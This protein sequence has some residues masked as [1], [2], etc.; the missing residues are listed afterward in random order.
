MSQ[1]VPT[2]EQ[3]LARALKAR[4]KR[5]ARAA[6]ARSHTRAHREAVRARHFVTLLA[7]ALKLP[8]DDARYLAT[9]GAASATTTEVAGFTFRLDPG[10]WRAAVLLVERCCPVCG[11]QFVQR[12]ARKPADFGAIAQAYLHHADQHTPAA[13]ADAGTPVESAAT[14]NITHR[15]AGENASL[16]AHGEE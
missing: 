6:R 12:G 5:V 2:E 8:A 10:Q 11:A 15:L 1:D 9:R 7:R 14:P 13:V 3:V 16:A 4:R